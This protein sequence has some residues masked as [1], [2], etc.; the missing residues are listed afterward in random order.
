[1]KWGIFGI[2]ALLAAVSVL[3]SLNAMSPDH[4]RGGVVLAIGM[5]AASAAM[6]IAAAITHAC[7][8]KAQP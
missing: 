4:H 8:R 5:A 3:A 1:M 2:G 6:M 7:G